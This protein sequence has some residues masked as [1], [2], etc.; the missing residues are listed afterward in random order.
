MDKDDTVC[1]LL[2]TTQCGYS[3]H[4]EERNDKSKGKEN[5]RE[6]GNAG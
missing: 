2:S 1:P 4:S 3:L 5:G 6:Y